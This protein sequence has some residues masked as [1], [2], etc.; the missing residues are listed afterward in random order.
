M[1]PIK[2]RGIAAI[3][4]IA[5][6]TGCETPRIQ[7]PTGNP[8]VTIG[9][10]E[11]DA[12]KAQ[13]VNQM[14]NQGFAITTDTVYSLQ[15]SKQMTG[16]SGAMYQ[17]LLGNAHSSTPTVEIGF[18]IVKLTDST[19][20]VATRAVVMQNAFGQVQRNTAPNPQDNAFIQTML[21]NIKSAVEGVISTSSTG[22]L[23]LR[24]GLENLGRIETSQLKTFDSFGALREFVAAEDLGVIEIASVTYPTLP[25]AEEQLTP[26]LREHAA[27]L[28]AQYLVVTKAPDDLQASL[29]QQGVSSKLMAAAFKVPPARIGV[30]YDVGLQKKGIFQIKSFSPKSK[31]ESGG[32]RV[33]DLVTK[34][35]GIIP[36]NYAEYARR[37]I[38]W[39]PGVKIK[40]AYERDGKPGETEVELF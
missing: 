40:I 1:Q 33:G 8:E 20:V 11:P 2:L 30:N 25:E 12:V 5:L 18:N 23:K 13:I 7:T 4:A 32:L 16:M 29:Q 27:S 34:M 39:A 37:A 31:A 35:D 15:F 24:A 38:K 6:F 21:L 17:A 28:G 3:I 22:P 36:S 9:S 19:R 14:V 10:V 26:K